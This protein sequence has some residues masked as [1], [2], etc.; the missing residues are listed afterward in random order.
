MLY[1]NALLALAYLEAHQATGDPFDACIA[2]EV[3]DYVARVMTAPEGGFYSAEDADSE[4]V[5]G[6]FYV[7]RRSELDDILGPDADL[8]AEAYDVT[9]RG[10]FEGANVL[11]LIG[12]DLTALARAHDLGA[13]ELAE[14]LAAAR[15]ALFAKR[16][17]RVH[18]HKD[19]KILTAWNGLMIAALARGAAVLGDDRYAD[20]AR[21]AAAMIEARLIDAGGRL[22]ARY[23]N[24]QAGIPAYIDDYAFYIYG[25]H[26]LFSATADPLLLERAGACCMT[27]STCS[28]TKPAAASSSPA[29]TRRR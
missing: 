11:N 4:G 13:A 18:P 26:E 5:E 8:F 17:E 14:R 19:D 22:L 25:L 3:F 15:T 16:E 2:R 6:K 27:P 23:R 10:N 21:R 12:R 7:W 24:G 29:G 1:D 28:G 20:M 9:E